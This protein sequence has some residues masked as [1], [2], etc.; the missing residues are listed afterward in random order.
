[1]SKLPFFVYG[2]LME[3]LHNHGVISKFVKEIK[4]ATL[5]NAIMYAIPSAFP[6]IIKNSEG[7]VKGE[8]IF[9]NEDSF[10]YEEALW[11]CDA[12]EGYDE[13][14]NEGLYIREKVT[15]ST[16]DENFEAWVYFAGTVEEYRK[17]ADL[18]EDGDY[19]NYLNNSIQPV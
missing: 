18:V 11:N 13:R 7:T 9:V 1:M 6:F 16:E 3:G 15:V 2:T 14:Y 5:K 17:K 8:L 19:K 12:L 4:S 10:P